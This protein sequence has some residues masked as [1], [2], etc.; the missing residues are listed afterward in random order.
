MDLN[1]NPLGRHLTILA[2]IVVVV[3]G[4]Q[5]FL[6]LAF[7]IFMVQESPLLRIFFQETPAAEEGWAGM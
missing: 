6:I 5:N 7:G 1:S 3:V 4:I 2:E